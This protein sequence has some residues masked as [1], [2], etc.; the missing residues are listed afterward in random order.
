MHY[1]VE[2]GPVKNSTAGLWT[3]LC[4]RSKD[5]AIRAGRNALRNIEA[6]RNRLGT[7]KAETQHTREDESVLS[8][9]GVPNWKSTVNECNRNDCYVRVHLP[10]ALKDR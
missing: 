3:D 7:F 10:I 8:F 6:G 5:V 9:D 4:F 1:N 2:I